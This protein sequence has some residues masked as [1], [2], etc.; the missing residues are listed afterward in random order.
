M[1]GKTDWNREHCFIYLCTSGTFTF[2]EG[3]QGSG[4]RIYTDKYRRLRAHYGLPVTVFLVGYR[5]YLTLP[6]TRATAPPLQATAA[7]AGMEAL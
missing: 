6:F 7:L 3:S 1:L 2:C 4:L 5:T